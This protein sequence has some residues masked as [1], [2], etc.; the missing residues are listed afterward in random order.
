ME[1]DLRGAALE[2]VR[3]WY[4]TTGTPGN[5]V[6]LGEHAKETRALLQ[7]LVL[8]ECGAGLQACASRIA[9]KVAL[10]GFTGIQQ[11]VDALAKGIGDETEGILRAIAP[12]LPFLS[13]ARAIASAKDRD[14]MGAVNTTL[15]ITPNIVL[16][17]GLAPAARELAEAATDPQKEI[18]RTLGQIVEV[19]RQDGDINKLYQRGYFSRFDSERETLAREKLAGLLYPLVSGLNGA[20]TQGAAPRRVAE[21]K[22]S[23]PVAGSPDHR[24]PSHSAMPS[25]VHD[26]IESPRLQP[27]GAEIGPTPSLVDAPA[28]AS[29]QLSSSSRTSNASTKTGADATVRFHLPPRPRQKHKSALEDDGGLSET[30][31]ETIAAPRRHVEDLRF[32]VERSRALDKSAVS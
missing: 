16:L 14:S 28:M 19:M 12:V 18:F 8:T 15:D 25:L 22:A 21:S 6:L 23:E 24:R 29:S 11:R 3:R 7:R 27:Q 31:A 10:Q 2:G 30:L 5:K 32:P 1:P 13:D 17:M 4:A 26:P 20:V 9:E